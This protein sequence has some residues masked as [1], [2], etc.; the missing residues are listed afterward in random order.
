MEYDGAVLPVV[1]RVGDVA[2]L[3][4]MSNRAVY[5]AIKRG[6]L[7]AVGCG[8]SIRILT[9]RFLPLLEYAR[10]PDRM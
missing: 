2:A 6:Q 5:A 9:S 1:L 4:G 3:L 8:R 10:H 7:P